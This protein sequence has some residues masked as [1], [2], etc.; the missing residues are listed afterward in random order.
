MIRVLMDSI[1]GIEE[2][3][4]GF[5]FGLHNTVLC[6]LHME[7]CVNEKLVIIALFERL[8]NRT[9]GVNLQAYFKDV[10]GIYNNG[11]T[12]KS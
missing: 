2:K 3:A 9:N 7:N 6:V 4:I 1:T 12:M 11:M 8:K 10:T 5:N